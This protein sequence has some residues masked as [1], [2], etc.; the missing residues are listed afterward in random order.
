[1]TPK[2]AGLIESALRVVIFSAGVFVCCAIAIAFEVHEARLELVTANAEAIARV[3]KLLWKID[4]GLEIA[5]ALRLDLGN[6]LTKIRSQVKQAS[7][8]STK[9]TAVQTKAA[10]VTV[11]KALDSTREAIQ[12][13]AGEPVTPA[14]P[15]P[16]PP[17]TV[18]VPPPVVVAPEKP[19]AAPPVE[20]TPIEPKRRSLWKRIFWPWGR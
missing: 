9:A 16:K 8:E 15:A 18:N 12:A 3:D 20:V 11:A 10:A 14:E 6:M 13:V 7:D 17:I 1:M 4:T 5:A 19:A 2:L